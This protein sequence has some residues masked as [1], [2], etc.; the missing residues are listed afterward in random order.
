MPD[1]LPKFVALFTEA[2]RTGDFGMV[3]PQRCA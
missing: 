3:R 2:E 1:L